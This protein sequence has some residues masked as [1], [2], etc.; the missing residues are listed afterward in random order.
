MTSEA[1]IQAR[2]LLAVGALPDVRLFRNTVG[3]GWQGTVLT[4]HGDTI[5]LR[6]ARYVTFGLAPGSADLIGWRR[7]LITAADVGSVFAQFTGV[8]VKTTK[9]RAAD[10]QRHF[11]DV[12]TNAGGCAGIA[13]SPD[14]ARDLLGITPRQPE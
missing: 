1:D 2:I 7:R 13:R 9:G 4:R 5:A 8:E 3:E 10:K 14:D 11:L 12:V 6:N